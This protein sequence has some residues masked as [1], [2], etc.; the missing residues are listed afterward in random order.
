MLRL[1]SLLAV[2]ASH[3][4]RSRRDLLLENLA[5]RQQL[6][7]LSRKHPQ[8]RLVASEKLF[9]V[10]LR[11]V[12]RGWKQALVLVQPQTVVQSHRA[13]FKLYWAWLS[14]YQGRRGRKCVNREL[15]ELILR[16]VVENRDSS[17]WRTKAGSK[18]YES[19]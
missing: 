4:L 8:P 10:L 11:R 3:F 16:M 6:A 15:R 18:S 12:W 7:V 14:R 1:L 9:W 2:L 13:G 19:D 17:A 5:L